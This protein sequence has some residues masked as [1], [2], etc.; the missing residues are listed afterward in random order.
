[1]K[2]E[3]KS[4]FV[5]EQKHY[6]KQTL[7]TLFSCDQ[8]KCRKLIKKLKNNILKGR[9]YSQPFLALILNSISQSEANS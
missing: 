3:I 9:D 4:V 1:M 8:E 5:K 6:T 2:K 7:C